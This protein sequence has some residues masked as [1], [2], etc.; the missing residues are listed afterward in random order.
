MILTLAELKKFLGMLSTDTANDDK[1]NKILKGAYK[2][3]E[4]Y[5]HTIFDNADYTQYISFN[6][7]RIKRIYTKYIPIVSVDSLTINNTVLTEDTDFYLDNKDK[8]VIDL[9]SIRNLTGIRSAKI[10]YNAG[11]TALT[12]PADLEVAIFKLTVRTDALTQGTIVP[13]DSS[14]LTFGIKEIHEV[15]NRYRR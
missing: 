3:A 9:V 12:F 8:G 14:I 1:L 7:D 5:C 11:Y 10:V 15:F 13:A 4:G 6:E 2:D